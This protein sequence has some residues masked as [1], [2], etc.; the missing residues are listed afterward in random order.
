[1][2]DVFQCEQVQYEFKISNPN[3]YGKLF[4]FKLQV[5]I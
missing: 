2:T 5:V 4:D 1:M 3:Y